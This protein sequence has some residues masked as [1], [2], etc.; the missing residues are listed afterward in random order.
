MVVSG[1]TDVQNVVDDE[2]CAAARRVFDAVTPVRQPFGP[3]A[4]AD[5]LGVC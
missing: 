5:D 1:S 2:Q 3:C 4:Q